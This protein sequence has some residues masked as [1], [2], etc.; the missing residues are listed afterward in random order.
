MKLKKFDY[1]MLLV[2]V[3]AALIPLA[4][5]YCGKIDME[6]YERQQ[7]ELGID[8][9]RAMH[10]RLPRHAPREDSLKTLE[11]SIHFYEDGF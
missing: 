1:L 2:V 4:F 5:L 11:D 10:R 7:Q 6:R 9:L 8:S 3:V